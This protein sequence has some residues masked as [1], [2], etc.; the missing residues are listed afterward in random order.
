MPYVTMYA[1]HTCPFCQRALRW[2]TEHPEWAHTVDVQFVDADAIARE[3]FQARGFRGVP[4]FVAPADQWSGWDPAR[5]A[6][7][8]EA[9]VADSR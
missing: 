1:T 4:A 7:A 2:L 9:R 3:A 5:L 6:R 8:L